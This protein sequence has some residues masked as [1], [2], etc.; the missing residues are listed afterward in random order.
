MAKA[1]RGI[2]RIAAA[3]IVVMMVAIVVGAGAFFG[4]Q[5]PP[6]KLSA[7]QIIS[8]EL[9]SSSTTQST[10]QIL[11]SESG[12]TTTVTATAGQFPPC[13][14]TLV[15]SNSNGSLYVST[16]AEVGDVVCI[17]ASLDNSSE[18]YL[19][20][21]NSTGSVVFS[22]VACIAGGPSAGDTCTAYWDT[23]QPS[24]QGSPIGPGVYRVM[25]SDYQG[26][27]VVLEAN[28]TLA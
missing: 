22:P 12:N 8:M 24:P 10:C 3:A 1:R 9:A 26:S 18:V 13:G 23:A 17:T 7:Q 4:S 21:A 2:G 25:A 19:S 20:V 16:T 15:D 27:P 6:E 14:C 11:E 28:F 5:G